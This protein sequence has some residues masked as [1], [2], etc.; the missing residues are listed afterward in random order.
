MWSIFLSAVVVLIAVLPL[1]PSRAQAQEQRAGVVTTLEG[2][3]TVTRVTARQ[4]LPLRFRDDV[5]VNDRIVTGDQ[6]LARMLLGGKA[7]VTVRER[8]AL[9]ITEV[10]GK[11][12]ITLDSG[13][14]ALNVGR[15]KMKPGEEIEV[16]TPNAVAGVRGTVFITEVVR[17]S[18]SL[19]AADTAVTTNFYGYTGVV[20]ITIGA[21]TF[22]LLPNTFWSRTGLQAPGAGAMTADMRVRAEA[23]LQP[24]LQPLGTATQALATEQAMNAASAM[25]AVGIRTL[26][27]LGAVSN[28][29][30]PILPGGTSTIATPVAAPGVPPA[31]PEPACSYN[32]GPKKEWSYRPR[33]W[34]R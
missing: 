25:A 7:V 31:P 30:A 6:S 5:F 3:A 33:A 1:A 20:S 19:D 29:T 8:S 14:I 17:A 22:S 28:V 34:R 21:Q 26:P 24:K 10:P 4:P 32:E 27:Q 15:E 23:G 16:R 9:T 18:A 2:N 13:K 12:T 11:S